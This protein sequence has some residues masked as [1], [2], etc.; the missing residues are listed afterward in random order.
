MSMGN[1]N[2]VCIFYG[3]DIL[4]LGVSSPDHMGWAHFKFHITLMIK[5]KII[6]N[7]S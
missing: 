1:V 5:I 2:I 7:I 6:V 3:I 4:T